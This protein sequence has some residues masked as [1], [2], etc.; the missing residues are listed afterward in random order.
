MFT[1]LFGL[2]FYCDSKTYTTNINI[3][4]TQVF[5]YGAIL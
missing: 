5:D 4:Y 2:S 3:G 1:Q